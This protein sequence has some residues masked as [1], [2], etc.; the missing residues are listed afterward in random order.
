VNDDK[1]FKLLFEFLF[2]NVTFN[3]NVKIL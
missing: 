1:Y 2:V 3:S